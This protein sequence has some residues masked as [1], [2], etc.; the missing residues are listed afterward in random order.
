MA[1]TLQDYLGDPAGSSSATSYGVYWQSVSWP[2]TTGFTVTRVGVHL[3]RVGSPG[4][5]TLHVRATDGSNKPTGADLASGTLNG[6]DFGTTADWQYFELGAGAA[7]ASGTRYAIIVSAASGNSS[8]YVTWTYTSSSGNV[9]TGDTRYSASS[10]SGATWGTSAATPDLG[11]RTYIGSGDASYVDMSVT[12]GGAGGGSATLTAILSLAATGGGA[13]GGSASLF[14]VIVPM[15][16]T[17][18][19]TGGGS[20][21][22][23]AE[24]YI[25]MSVTG[26]GTNGGSATLET[27]HYISMSATGGGTGGGSAFMLSHVWLDDFRQ[28]SWLTAI[29]NDQFWFEDVD[30]AAGTMVELLAARDDIDCT[31]QLVLFPLLEKVFVVNGAKKKV[32]DFGNV[33]ITTADVG[34]HAPDRGNILTGG[35][36]EAQMAVDYITTTSG[37]CTIYGK[38]T[39][40]A[41][42]ESGETVTGVDDA[43]DAISFVLNADEDSG[44]TKAGGQPHWYDW[45]VYG[46]DT[47]A[48]GTMPE[49]VYLGCPYRGRAVLA[50]NPDYPHQWYMSREGNPFDFNY[51]ATD[52]QRPMAGGTGNLGEL[53]D[54]CRALIPWKDD[55]LAFGCI[56][57]F[58]VLRGNPADGGYMENVDS[59]VGV[60]GQNAFTF[61]GEGNLYFWGSGGIYRSSRGFGTL[62]NLTAETYPD[63]VTEED[64]DPATHRVALAYDVRNHGIQVCVTKLSDGSNSC[65][66]HDLRTQGFYPDGY[67]EDHGVYSMLYYD[68]NDPD[69]K[70]L[71]L[72][73]KDGYIRRFD[74]T[75]A[76]D[77]GT[78]IDSYVDYGP[79][80]LADRPDHEGIIFSVHAELGGGASGS[81]ETDSNNVTWRVWVDDSADGVTEKLEADATP[82][83][84]GTFQAP[85][86][87]KGGAIKRKVKGVYAGV[88]LRNNTLG[89][90]WGFEK[91]IVGIR[92]TGRAK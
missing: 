87:R 69:L 80:Q 28:T 85:G 10:D 9:S 35:D 34:A 67:D 8:N 32:A 41:T 15:S 83:I 50:G 78:A 66:W 58:L 29:G 71:L 59:K 38:R 77:D 51:I 3:K 31:D 14:G 48:Y 54:M 63:V 56:N 2:T 18:G 21:T 68:A 5:V 92:P 88:K 82:N 11:F 60:Y 16:V 61:D 30:V 22:L 62:T 81:T 73:C 27:E 4:T 24:R 89:E 44:A 6:N 43:E 1:Y 75:S 17:G 49:T 84:A 55:S 33:K 47:A 23:E 74:P 7:L 91:M 37:A 53:G 65:Y 57:S 12:G 86:R 20:A 19:G 26:G 42:F 52:A 70:Y 36:S 79:I 64:A 39:T 46:S 25:S 90:T 45:A 76:N 72:G 13:G 40:E